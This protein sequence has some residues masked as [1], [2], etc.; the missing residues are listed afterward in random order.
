MGV[1]KH[2]V[3]NLFH[4]AAHQLL[5]ATPVGFP[6]GLS[7]RRGVCKRT[8]T[9]PYRGFDARTGRKLQGAFLICLV[10]CLH[11]L[12]VASAA[13]S[14]VRKRDLR[15]PASMTSAQALFYNP[16]RAY[17]LFPPA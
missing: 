8:Q 2:S 5:R 17:I 14:F 13:R 9:R 12:P 10:S 4:E 3:L 16:P 11:H 1:R 15:S 6:E 7:A